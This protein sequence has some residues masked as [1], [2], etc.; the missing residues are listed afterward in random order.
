MKR[1]T[2]I[3]TNLCYLHISQDICYVQMTDNIGILTI[4]RQCAHL[5][6]N[7]DDEPWAPSPASSLL[8][9]PGDVKEP[10]QL[11]SKS[12]ESG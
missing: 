4:Y 10:T 9:S 6:N 3:G 5:L 11:L 12:L 8:W 2:K 7:K 1:R